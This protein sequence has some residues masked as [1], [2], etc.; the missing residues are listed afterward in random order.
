MEMDT[1]SLQTRG[2]RHGRCLDAFF[3]VSII[4]LFVAVGAVAACG[5][6]VV[7]ELKVEVDGM[8]RVKSPE[9]RI[10][11]TSVTAYK[12]QNFVYLRAGSSQLMNT[13]MK[14]SPV[15][16]GEGTSIGNI[17]TFNSVHHSLQPTRAGNYFMYIELNLTCTYHCNAG[18]LTVRLGDQL[19][20]SV[21]LHESQDTTPVS[22]KCWTVA[23]MDGKERLVTKM[24][25]PQGGLDNWTLDKNRSG[26]GMFLV[27]P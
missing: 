25:V 9:N 1:E 26:Q 20:C 21:K 17:F 22:K 12:M 24:T 5:I 8:R 13:T 23:Q 14:W 11:G 15:N 19:T 10:G 27:D 16:H 6:M 18:L 3:V 7:M 4:F 2:R